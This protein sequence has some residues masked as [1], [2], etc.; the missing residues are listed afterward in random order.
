MAKRN[1]Q[2]LRLAFLQKIQ[3]EDVFGKE[4]QDFIGF[5]RERNF[6]FSLKL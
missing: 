6:A 2:T 1:V 5:S 3:G 4:Y